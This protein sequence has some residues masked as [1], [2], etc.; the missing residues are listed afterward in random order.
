MCGARLSPSMSSVTPES[1]MSRPVTSGLRA[2]G[3]GTAKLWLVAPT[4]PDSSPGAGPHGSQTERVCLFLLAED[5]LLIGLRL[6]FVHQKQP[7][8][9]GSLTG[10]GPWRVYDLIPAASISAQAVLTER[11]PGTAHPS[12]SHLSREQCLPCPHQSPLCSATT[13]GLSP[14]STA[15]LHCLFPEIHPTPLPGLAHSSE[16]TPRLN[17]PLCFRSSLV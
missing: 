10:V 17:S 7:S 6:V 4:H 8:F 15:L 14:S 3:W 12:G 16:H 2:M 1:Q 9:H 5:A 13:I 11:A